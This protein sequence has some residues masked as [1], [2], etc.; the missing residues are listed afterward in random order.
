MKANLEKKY[1]LNDTDARIHCI[2][3]DFKESSKIKYHYHE[4]IEIL[5]FLSG[6]GFVFVNGQQYLYETD[7]L[8]IVNSQRAH[9]IDITSPSKYICIKVMPDIFY[10]D[11]F[12]YVLPFI[13]ETKDAY[14][15]EHYETVE[16]KIHS[17]LLYIIQE[18]NKMDIGF[19]TVIRSQILKFFIY[20]LRYLNKNHRIYLSNNISPEIQTALLY[21][22]DHYATVTEQELANI[23]HLSYNYFSY[24]FKENTGKSFIKHLNDTKIYHAEKMLLS[25]QKTITEISQETGFATDSHFISQFRK[26]NG[27]TPAKF[28]KARSF[29]SR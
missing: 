15:F 12:Q 25:T 5:Y 22:S 17:L 3:F 13:S 24:L 6:T 14:V 29:A 2:S 28:R 27:T 21:I 26:K 8:V 19:E 1:K 11:Q 20:I 18:W 16:M 9:G 4:Y 23:C 7:T 10:S